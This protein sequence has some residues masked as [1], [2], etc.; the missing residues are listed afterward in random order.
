ME[1]KKV[2]VIIPFFN[3]EKTLTF[4]LN[5]VCHQA[6]A[7]DE[8]ILVDNNSGDGS[9][10]IVN[11]FIKAFRH[12]KISYVTEKTPGPSAARNKGAF[13]SRGEWLL[14]LD[15]DC[16]PSQDYISEMLFHFEENEIGAVAGCIHPFPPSNPVQKTLSLFSLPENP[17][18]AVYDETSITQGLYPTAN[19]AVRKSVFFAVGGF[20]LSLRYGEDHDFCF[21]VY[22]A[23]Y[24]IKVVKNAVVRHIHRRNLKGLILQSFWAGAVHP[25][26]LKHFSPGSIIVS[27]PF[28][29]VNIPKPSVFI[30]IDLNQADKKFSASLFP[31][32]LWWPFGGLGIVY[33]FYLCLFVYK[34]AKAKGISISFWELPLISSLL[35]LKSLCLTLGRISQSF[36]QKVICF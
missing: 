30:W 27:L 2:S 12:L 35:I 34:K 33:I 6:A 3:A 21:R 25:Y 13:V 18:E 19:L 14:F 1:K 31:A 16:V 7:P 17:K 20:N 22:R 11:S 9:K 32:L 28:I 24:K 10:E 15:S 4:C 23:G 36:T 29:Q 8:I 5:A 26:D